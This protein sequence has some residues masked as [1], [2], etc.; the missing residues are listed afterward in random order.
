MEGRAA[1]GLHGEGEGAQGVEVGREVGAGSGIEVLSCNREG[2]EAQS[3]EGGRGDE[4]SGV[5]VQYILRKGGVI[6]EEGKLSIG[7]DGSRVHGEGG[8][9]D[10]RWLRQK[11]TD[12]LVG[13]GEVTCK[14]LLAKMEE[15]AEGPNPNQ[16]EDK[17]RIDDYPYEDL[18]GAAST[19]R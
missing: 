8:G 4:G 3:V 15:G 7:K 17:N 6:N 16:E 11:Q 12:D 13:G 19:H 2:K 5:G 14:D 9:G 1:E 18:D 10:F